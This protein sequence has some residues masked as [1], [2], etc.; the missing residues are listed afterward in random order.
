[1]SILEQVGLAVSSIFAE[2]C[3]FGIMVLGV[4][5]TFRVLDFPDLTVEG[6]F[7]LGAA[8]MANFIVHGD[9]PLL[10]V[11]V[12]FLGGVL[13]GMAT[14][15][16][17]NELKIP[18]LLAGI[19]TMI[20]LYSINLR[21]LGS[22]NVPLF[23]NRTILTDVRGSLSTAFG[24]P[25]LVSDAIFFIL[26][27]F[28]VKILIDLFFRTDL[29]LTLGALGNNQ[30]M[31]VSQ[32]VNPKALKIIGVGLSNGLVALAGSFNAQYQGFGDVQLGQAI[33]IAGLA[34]VMIGEFLIRS[35]KIFWLTLNVILGSIIFN[36]VMYGARVII[37]LPGVN[38]IAASDLKIVQ[39]LLVVLCLILIRVRTMA[40]EKRGERRVRRGGSHGQ[41]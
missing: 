17:H 9:S 19:L 25:T 16:M 39:V 34:S 36:A 28:G 4:F 24:F 20:M 12:A 21:I 3:M 15:V 1:V 6:S 10:A 38:F 8:I 35:N 23:N 13:A 41:A 30:Q 14:A 33:I 37:S 29:G 40:R 31:I 27:V 5:I 22:S 18:N 11:F 7:P 2:G 32:G 26:L